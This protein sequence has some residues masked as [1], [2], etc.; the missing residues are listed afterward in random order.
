MGVP[1]GGSVGPSVCHS[2]LLGSGLLNMTCL[3]NPLPPLLLCKLLVYCTSRC[4]DPVRHICRWISSR[5]LSSYPLSSDALLYC[6]LLP[7]VS[8]FLHAQDVLTTPW[9][10]CVRPPPLSH[11]LANCTVAVYLFYVNLLS[12]P[13]ALGV[14]LIL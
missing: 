3:P 7:F 13:F 14:S 10:K 12:S 6:Y 8:R 2:V 9:G 11:C 1:V 5:A 4:A